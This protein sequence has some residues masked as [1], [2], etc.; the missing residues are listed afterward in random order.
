MGAILKPAAIRSDPR[1]R[2][3]DEPGS[4][5]APW[6]HVFGNARGACGAPLLLLVGELLLELLHHTGL[7]QRADIAE[8]PA[9]GDV[10]QQPAH[11]LAGAR[12]RHVGGPDDAL[13]PGELPDPHRDLVAHLRLELLVPLEIT[14]EDHEGADGLPGV[15]VLLTDDCRL[16]HLWMGDDGRLDRRG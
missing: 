10:P 6:R 2:K 14:L 7:T 1:S 9:F 4:R 5:D 8:L 12:L 11:D 13:R 15:L 3:T 16:G